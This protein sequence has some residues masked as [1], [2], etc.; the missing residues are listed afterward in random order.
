M[1]DDAVIKGSSICG[2]DQNWWAGRQ[3]YSEIIATGLKFGQL[4]ISSILK[5]LKFE[6]FSAES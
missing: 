1:Q 4:K 6:T 2:N 5:V 3:T